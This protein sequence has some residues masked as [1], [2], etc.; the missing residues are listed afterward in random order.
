MSLE[1]VGA[2]R[3]R[4]AR[5]GSQAFLQAQHLLRKRPFLPEPG[6]EQLPPL[7]AAGPFQLGSSIA[8]LSCCFAP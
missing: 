4:R 6:L 1:I 3:L 2:R 7:P 8:H 5:N